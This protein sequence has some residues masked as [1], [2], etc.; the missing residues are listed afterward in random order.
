MRIG[1]AIAALALPAL[2]SSA[3]L[4]AAPRINVPAQDLASA[5]NELARQAKIEILF[6]PLKLRGKRA[7]SLHGAIDPREALGRLLAGSGFEA[8]QARGSTYVLV[9]VAVPPRRAPQATPAEPE[10]AASA[11]IPEIVIVASRSLDTDI[12]RRTN[13]VQP[14]RV[15]DRSTIE[16]SQAGTSEELMRLRM[17]S[18]LQALTLSQE[19]VLANGSMRSQIDL[20]GLGT[21][22]TLVLIDGR[23]L[24]SVPATG[25]FAQPDVNG[26]SLAAIDRIET[27]GGTAGGIYGPGATGGVVNIVLRRDDEAPWI[28]VESGMSSRGD[29]WRW[30]IDGGFSTTLDDGRTHLMAILGHSNDDG[31]TF[32]D[33]DISTIAHADRVSRRGTHGLAISVPPVSPSLNI[34][35]LLI[36][37]LRFSRALGGGSIGSMITNIPLNGGGPDADLAA[38]V[39]A[40]AGAYDLRLSADGS[41][42][43][44]SFT[45]PFEA[46]TLITSARREI[47]PSLDLFIDGIFLE[48]V[49]RALGPRISTRDVSIPAGRR[50]NPFSGGVFASFST[51]GLTA[52]YET[53]TQ[54]LRG[55]AG[56]IWRLGHRWSAEFDA[57]LG[58]T[59]VRTIIP[60]RAG[61]SNFDPF[62]PS[63][64]IEQA[65]A[66][67]VPPPD[68]KRREIN[69]LHD[70]S[71]RLSGPVL[72]LPGGPLTM[73]LQAESR[74]EHNPGLTETVLG[75]PTNAAAQP[76][77]QNIASGYIEARAPLVAKDARLVPLR[78]LE[79][80]LAVRGDRY[81]LSG[82]VINEQTGNQPTGMLITGEYKTLAFTLGGRVQPIRDILL[83][84]SYARGYL[85]PSLDQ[86]IPFRFDLPP[87]EGGL[88]PD[89]PKRPGM[90]IATEGPFTVSD[91]GSPLARPERAD[92]LS[93]GVVLMPR[94]VRGLRLSVDFTRIKL[95]REITNFVGSNFAFVILREDQ[96]PGRVIRAPLTPEDQAKGFAGG[97]VTFVDTGSLNIGKSRAGTFDFDVDFTRQTRIGIFR[98]YATGSLEPTFRRQDDP[99]NGFPNLAGFMDGPLKWKGNAGIEW[100]KGRLSL[101]TNM[102]FY[103]GYHVTLAARD[104]ASLAA[105][106]FNEILQGGSS[107]GAQYYLDLI[108]R[109]RIAKFDFAIGVSNVFDRQP[110][111]V[112]PEID[113]NYD[114]VGYS[115]YGD[116]R[117]RRF[118]FTASAHF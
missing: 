82:P 2:M 17:P 83:R 109:Y 18:N 118:T 72:D 28:R 53:K 27:L 64:S 92:T 12:R 15:I 31:I 73:T 52:T 1:T 41:G 42:T 56:L 81:R 51:P 44:Q 21:E 113:P 77:T 90:E 45:T 106:S 9:A 32:G 61:L 117:G 24:P 34:E 74:R 65:L 43:K 14:Y 76:Q 25:S 40:G 84:A 86:I 47:T 22:H 70:F 55:T 3:A 102:Q 89:D 97:I 37:P 46:T 26:L 103:S 68:H 63:S 30:R 96:F 4:G 33:R 88:L 29:A 20:R 62:S 10:P 35:G 59:L 104:H 85:P 79:L 69:R 71:L 100:S 111:L 108:A 48:D 11:A 78:G 38:L 99:A 87:F 13:D 67:Y 23:R 16:K 8:R 93:G 115:P 19:P 39:R 80:Q 7:P 36:Q 95:S 75:V 5:L 57:S 58:S 66:G 114:G 54:T 110:P 50:G 94:F 105:S 91:G 6:D 116:P 112:I 60:D 107:V 98:L 101:A 49:G